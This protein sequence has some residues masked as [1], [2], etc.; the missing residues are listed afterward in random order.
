MT[1]YGIAADNIRGGLL[2]AV[3]E[4]GR[5]QVWRGDPRDEMM[6][7]DLPV[8]TGQA[9]VEHVASTGE[10]YLA[11]GFE[12][13]AAGEWN[14]LAWWADRD[15][16]DWQLID[17]PP[18]ADY[19]EQIVG[20]DSAGT[21]TASGGL[22]DRGSITWDFDPDGG[23]SDMHEGIA[24]LIDTQ[25]AFGYSAVWRRPNGPWRE[26]LIRAGRFDAFAA[27]RLSDGWIVAG[28]AEGI[29]PHPFEVLV[30]RDGGPWREL[31]P[32]GSD[33][34]EILDMTHFAERVLGV[35]DAVY[36]GPTSASEY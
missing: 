19:L 2:M 17:V 12:I 9:T 14:A 33:E 35:G 8:A 26:R 7:T 23:W 34:P 5:P 25:T 31:T 36:I 27:A 30:A 10:G 21:F 24:Y 20:N 4:D 18:E 16:T 1:I 11:V 22:A 6:I 13:V 3:N 28:S 32:I 15:A 29:E